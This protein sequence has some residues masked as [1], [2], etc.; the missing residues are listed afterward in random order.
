[1]ATNYKSSFYKFP[2]FDGVRSMRF[3]WMSGAWMLPSILDFSAV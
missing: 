1:M 3:R 2:N